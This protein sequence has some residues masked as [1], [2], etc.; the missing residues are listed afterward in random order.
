MITRLTLAFILAA[1]FSSTADARFT[2]ADLGA[3][4]ITAPDGKVYC[5]GKLPA[6]KFRR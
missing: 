2:C 4:T 1:G 3:C 6:C 5:G